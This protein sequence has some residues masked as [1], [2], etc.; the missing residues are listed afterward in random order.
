MPIQHLG[1]MTWIENKARSVCLWVFDRA[2]IHRNTIQCQL[3]QSPHCIW[4]LFLYSFLGQPGG[5][6]GSCRA[7][8]ATQSTC[9]KKHSSREN[10]N[11]G[12]PFGQAFDRREEGK[13]SNKHHS[14]RHKQA[15]RFGAAASRP[16]LA[17]CQWPQWYLPA[18]CAT[19]PSL[20]NCRRT[21]LVNVC[22]CECACVCVR[23]CL[24]VSKCVASASGGVGNEFTSQ[25]CTAESEFC[26]FVFF[27]YSKTPTVCF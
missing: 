13:H 18:S 11:F 1:H 20:I 6:S 4:I 22:V 23:E 8:E 14:H 24:Y 5:H 9:E 27:F 16:V 17:S 15:C 2:F 10:S 26:F 7:Q 12:K 25:E 19:Q 21:I 3:V